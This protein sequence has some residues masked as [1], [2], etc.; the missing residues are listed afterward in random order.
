MDSTGFPAPTSC[1]TS[2]SATGAILGRPEAEID[3]PGVVLPPKPSGMVLRSQSRAGRSEVVVRADIGLHCERPGVVPRPEPEIAR[4]ET[5][6]APVAGPSS[7][8][9]A[10][11]TSI[12]SPP[13]RC[14]TENVAE[15]MSGYPFPARQEL[16]ITPIPF[17]PFHH[18]EQSRS[19]IFFWLFLIGCQYQCNCP[20]GKI[21]SELSYTG[22][23]E[24]L[25]N[26]CT[27]IR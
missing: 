20:T 11:G 25:K 22:L 4:P 6:F 7:D 18:T 8:P 5:E 13:T 16:E 2:M 21:I 10:V 14:G 19:L 27:L 17:H 12:L 1:P 24:T 9:T 15:T 23:M 26:S 3:R